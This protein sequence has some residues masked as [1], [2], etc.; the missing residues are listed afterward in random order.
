MEREDLIGSVAAVVNRQIGK[1]SA[2]RPEANA[3]LLREFEEANATWAAVA[4]AGQAAARALAP[5][6]ERAG[7]GAVASGCDQKLKEAMRHADGLAASLEQAKSQ[8]FQVSASKAP[9]QLGRVG[10]L[11]D[12]AS[13][14]AGGFA[15][16]FEATFDELY[17]G[18]AEGLIRQRASAKTQ[19]AAAG[20]LDAESRI[21]V[22]AAF[23]GVLQTA[24]SIVG[25][26]L[27]IT[28]AL[29]GGVKSGLEASGVRIDKSTAP[30]PGTPRL[31]AATAVAA[32]AGF[33]Y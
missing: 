21:E 8:I 16:A 10:R 25:K 5:G 13:K 7:M 4:A 31:L 32:A 17:E 28:G 26:T 27:G 14:D 23:S 19:A 29:A 3:T 30:R 22:K 11:V 2:G 20:P 33:A 6:L 12:E 18:V 15:E 9:A 24:Q 1:A